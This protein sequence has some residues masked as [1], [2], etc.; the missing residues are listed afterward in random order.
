ME[1]KMGMLDDILGSAVPQ[2]GLAKPLTLSLLALLASGALS[3]GSAQ[4]GAAKGASA[5]SADAGTGD[6]LGGLGGL[7]DRFQ[8]NGLG[9]VINSWIGPGAN[10]AVT[11]GQLSSALGPDVIKSLTQ[12]SGM[13]QQDLMAQLSQILPGVVDKLTPN[14]RLPT[15]AEAAGFR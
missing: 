11:P 6:V 5:A 15:Q 13:S 3:K 14:G 7:L 9:D 2:G 1:G 12:K 4:A 8:Q 10:K